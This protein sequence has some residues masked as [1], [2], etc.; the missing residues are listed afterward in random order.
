MGRNKKTVNYGVS[1]YLDKSYLET[2]LGDLNTEENFN[3]ALK[4]TVKLNELFCLQH[5]ILYIKARNFH[6]I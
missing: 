5:N 4:G 1:G 6:S 2:Q 3:I